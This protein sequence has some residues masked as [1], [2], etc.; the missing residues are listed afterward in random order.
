MAFIEIKNLTKRFDN[1]LVINNLSFKIDRGEK[2]AIKG[3][4]GKGKTTLLRML[5]GIGQPDSGTIN[6]GGKTLSN[7]SAKELRALIGYLPQGIDL[8][9]DNGN[10]LCNLLEIDPE[11]IFNHL[12]ALGLNKNK[13]TQP[14]SE[15]SGGEKQRLLTS[16]ILGLK[17]PIVI[18]DEPTSALDSNSIQKLIKLIWG[19]PNLTVIST[20]H[21]RTWEQQCDK[22][23]D[24]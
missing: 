17:R 5:T 12:E 11:S 8:L 4:S 23:I 6:F 24:L 13:L 20:T 10:Q 19:I 15:L 1:N 22:I 9:I 7:D 21:N 18:L 16:I 14:L 2:V 3:E